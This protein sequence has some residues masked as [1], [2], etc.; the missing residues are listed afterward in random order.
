MSVLSLCSL[1]DDCSLI[2]RLTFVSSLEGYRGVWTFCRRH[3][4]PPRVTSAWA[5]SWWPVASTMT[6]WYSG[7]LRWRLSTESRVST[8]TFYEVS[9]TNLI[10][11]IIKVIWLIS[12]VKGNI[13]SNPLYVE[14]AEMSWGRTPYLLHLTV[15]R[16]IYWTPCVHPFGLIKSVQT[17]F[18]PV[19][20]HRTQYEQEETMTLLSVTSWPAKDGTN[21]RF[22]EMESSSSATQGGHETKAA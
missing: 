21:I 4:K 18:F 16:H 12:N 19:V 8:V 2:H 13:R 20:S 1:C 17:G 3:R 11:S 10:L 22:L 15:L 7:H 14:F 5:L 6:L 9:L